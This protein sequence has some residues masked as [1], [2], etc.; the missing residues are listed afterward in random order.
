MRGTLSHDS[1]L[2][3]IVPY[4]ELTFINTEHVYQFNTKSNQYK[5]GS[6]LKTCIH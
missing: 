4:N 5:T 1:L 6:K 2:S 3:L